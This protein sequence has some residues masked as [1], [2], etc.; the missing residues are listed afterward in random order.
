[1]E[2][3]TFV[4]LKTLVTQTLDLLERARQVAVNPEAVGQA[5]VTLAKDNALVAEGKRIFPKRLY[6]SEWQI[7][8]QLKG[9]ADA[10]RAAK[11]PALAEIKQT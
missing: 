11:Q 7:A 5:I 1:G 9:L 8:R 2:G 3:D 4:D 6:D 10:G